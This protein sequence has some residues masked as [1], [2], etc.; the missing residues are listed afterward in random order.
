MLINIFNKKQIT[1]RMHSLVPPHSHLALITTSLL[2][3]LHFCTSWT[4]HLISRSLTLFHFGLCLTPAVSSPYWSFNCVVWHLFLGPFPGI[5]ARVK[6]ITC[7]KT[8]L[9]RHQTH[10]NAGTALVITHYWEITQLQVRSIAI[11]IKRF[12]DQ[13]NL[14]LSP[15]TAIKFLRCLCAV[16]LNSV[17][18]E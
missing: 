1:A 9:K 17:F 7:N 13:L 10:L 5:S 18:Q 11:S 6:M 14:K 2:G 8:P 4:L 3:S 12:L 15:S 16:H